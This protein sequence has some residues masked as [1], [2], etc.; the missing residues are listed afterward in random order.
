MD[1][2]VSM[3]RPERPQRRLQPTTSP[4]ANPA[5]PGGAAAVALAAP[6]AG[7]RRALPRRLAGRR[8]AVVLQGLWFYRPFRGASRARTSAVGGEP[9]HGP[10]AV[11]TR[12]RASLRDANLR[13][14]CATQI[15]GANLRRQCA[16]QIRDANLR[17]GRDLDGGAAADA[18]REGR[19]RVLQPG[20][21]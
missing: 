9:R 11:E 3:G 7:K 8:D 17:V 2:V 6:N 13:R 5:A 20:P 15:C 1:A 19:D 16:T 14:R 18:G 12:A 4:A 21:P 10:P